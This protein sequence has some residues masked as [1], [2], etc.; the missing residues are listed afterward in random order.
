MIK[1]VHS[2]YKKNLKSR[3]APN[4]FFHLVTD[5]PDS[6]ESSSFEGFANEIMK[7]KQNI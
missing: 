3:E 5:D 6:V 4:C 1:V 2:V 7:Q